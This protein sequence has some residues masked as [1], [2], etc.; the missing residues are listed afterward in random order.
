MSVTSNGGHGELVDSRELS[1]DV[2]LYQ[3]AISQFIHD[4]SRSG[5]S[6]FLSIREESL[7]RK[8]SSPAVLFAAVF[9]RFVVH[10]IF[11]PVLNSVRRSL[12]S[13]Q[14]TKKIPPLSCCVEERLVDWV[15]DWWVADWPSLSIVSS[16]SKSSFC[17][18]CHCSRRSK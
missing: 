15:P 6:R 2:C 11:T 3:R 9:P 12:R 18:R 14:E 13:V 10:H 16:A 8:D 5:R 1:T 7:N 4:I 17:S